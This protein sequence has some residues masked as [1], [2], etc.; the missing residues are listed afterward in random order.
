MSDSVRALQELKTDG[1]ARDQRGLTE[2]E[3]MEAIRARRRG[4]SLAQIADALGK[5]RPASYLL[6]A[7]GTWA[8]RYAKLP[9]DK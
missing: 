4:A 6:S 9:E 8:F 1:T 3:G 7:L 2:A 5:K